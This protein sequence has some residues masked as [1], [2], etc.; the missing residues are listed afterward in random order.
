MRLSRFTDIG[1]RAL[2]YVGAHGRRVSSAEIAEAFGI[3]RDHVTKSLQALVG[4][5]AMESTPGR[6]GGYSVSGDLGRL[7]LG[8]VVRKLEPRV[9][10]AE[11]IGAESECPLTSTCELSTA[12]GRAQRSFFDA[13]DE[14]T[15]ADLVE[16]TRA[17]LVQLAPA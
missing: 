16:G 8:E 12:L 3:S 2:M 7:R 14:Y 11:C 1:L 15:V 6:N 17:P 10:M 13:L 4:L 5:G 9:E